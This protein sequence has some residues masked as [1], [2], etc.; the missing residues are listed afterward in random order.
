M[1]QSPSWEANRFSASL[2]IPRILCNQKVHYGIHKCAP[3]VRILSQLDPVH[4]PTFHF[5]YI[6]LNPLNAELNPICHL[7][8]LIGTHHILHVSRIRVNIIFP[9]SKNV[10]IITKIYY[11]CNSQPRLGCRC[12]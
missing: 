12:F 5:L 9:R 1:E 2:E 10:M 7:L 6:R 4:A 8:G 11:K 3:P